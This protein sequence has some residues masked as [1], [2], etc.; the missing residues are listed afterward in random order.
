MDA[1]PSDQPVRSTKPPDYD[2]S[3][4][5]HQ[6]RETLKD[7]TRI[8]D[9]RQRPD[10]T[11]GK[12]ADAINP[13]AQMASN[14]GGLDFLL[15]GVNSLSE[16]LP[17]LVKVLDEISKIHPYIGIVVGAFKVVIELEVKRRD[18]DKKVNL[19]FLE[20]KNMMSALLQLQN[21]RPN[22][23]GR[24]GITV[25]ARLEDLV[26]DAAVDIKECANACDTYMR[27]RLLVKV[28]KGAIWDETLK[29][30]VQTFADRKTAFVF[31]LSIHTGMSIDQAND[32]LDELMNRMDILLEFFQ[33]TSSYEQR[34]LRNIIQKAGGVEQVLQQTATMQ[35][36][37]DRERPLEDTV[38]SYR[39][40]GAR[41]LGHFERLRRSARTSHYLSARPSQYHPT[42]GNAYRESYYPTVPHFARPRT[43]F[44]GPSDDEDPRTAALAAELRELKQELADTP[45]A[46][47]RKNLKIF[48]RRFQMQQREILEE[49]RKVVIHEGDRVIS[50]VLAGPHERIIDPTL[51]EIWKDMRWR[52]IVKARHLVLALH[53][54]YMQ[55]MEDQ[56]R[57][58]KLDPSAPRRISEADTWTLKYLGL[59]ELQRI[60]EALD[61]DASGYITIQEVNRFAT[62]RPQG[63]S[64]LHWL[65]YWAVGW[66]L[67]MTEYKRKIQNLLGGI[68]RSL[69][70]VRAPNRAFVSR[71]L[72]VVKRLVDRMT[73]QFQ[74]N[75]ENIALLPR[76]QAYIHQ[77]E[78]QLRE[79]LEIAKYDIDALDTLA[80]VNGRKGLEKNLY[81]VVYLMLLHHLE[82]IRAG[83][84]VILHLE[85]LIDAETAMTIIEDGY[86]LR[87]SLLSALFQQRRLL[88]HQEIEDF[89]CGMFSGSTVII[90]P[91]DEPSRSLIGN[92]DE[93]DLTAT[94]P[95]FTTLKYPPHLDEFYPV[96][97]DGRA[98]QTDSDNIDDSLQPLLGPW[99]G[100]IGV[101]Y[102]GVPV[103]SILN[104]VFHIA[105]AS[106]D[107]VVASPLLFQPWTST[108]V[109]LV[110]EK[111]ESDDGR[112]Y[113]VTIRGNSSFFSSMYLRLRLSDDGT[114][115]A[116]YCYPTY[117]FELPRSPD[118]A[119][120]KPIPVVLK[121]NSSP[122]VMAFY[123]STAE[124]EAGRSRALWRFAISAV[125]YRIR[126]RN[127]SWD[128]IKSRRD[129][130]RRLVSL[131]YYEAIRDSISGPSLAEESRR[132]L[133]RALPGD[134]HFAGYA[135]TDPERFPW[136][137]PPCLDP[138]PNCQHPGLLETTV[139]CVRCLSCSPASSYPGYGCVF[140]GV[141]ECLYDHLLYRSPLDSSG[142]HCIVK[143]R[144]LGWTM[145]AFQEAT[146]KST[147]ELLDRVG[148]IRKMISGSS[149]GA[150]MKPGT[151]VER[152][153]DPRPSPLMQAKDRLKHNGGQ[154]DKD[155]D[156]P[157]EVRE[158]A[159]MDAGRSE[160]ATDRNSRPVLCITC[161]EK[162]TL[163][164]WTCAECE[165]SVTICDA[166][167]KNGG[168]DQGTHKSTHTLLLAYP[169]EDT[170]SRS[171]SPYSRSRRRR[172]PL[173]VAFA[174]TA[175]QTD[176]SGGVNEQRL[177]AVEERLTKIEDRFE[178]VESGVARMERMLAAAL[179]ALNVPPAT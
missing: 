65:A 118:G 96:N 144:V 176:G 160:T 29:G 130:N 54:Y 142:Q 26:K 27:K 103:L 56:E 10:S 68:Q 174:P 18:N 113:R 88:V 50:S 110:A 38:Q 49:M 164:C 4:E 25:G 141:T 43:G 125:L 21:V 100:L 35:E 80:L 12:V 105:P 163:P 170:R 74:G 93:I 22:H 16:S 159:T 75:A 31:A 132:L 24:D 131:L 171:V 7:A 69:E 138:S 177:E 147:V 168:I 116:G 48:E 101:L 129:R 73:L 161:T 166:C 102:Q 72:S 78:A 173:P 77:E 34:T 154:G 145:N 20:M 157:Q 47:M 90:V 120:E 153:R 122:E 98:D 3:S 13:T 14:S 39:G 162:V 106:T 117:D 71:Y 126:Q 52:G 58:L 62:S 63:W 33:K 151:T 139:P 107:Q 57:D 67:S 128:F 158:L 92:P 1:L 41:S 167:D 79:A 97:D 87:S 112:T 42:P 127:F 53:D 143:T 85:E 82:I 172:S 111:L 46:A 84:V 59:T 108:H 89:A 44:E 178:A 156:E 136:I 45:A 5:V 83:H 146:K 165:E 135:A 55:K 175:V 70:T 140:C 104:A 11:F 15:D 150:D 17:A 32:K 37:L 86:V 8:H 40:M 30:Y 6:A 36:L 123:P 66:Q 23:V 76:F 114:T 119:E 64:L 51:Y 134:L 137:L 115:L 99:T 155:G 28:I 121:H 124:R 60:I 152:G 148:T 81:V 95:P 2:V 169:G 91:S 149:E 9:E 61:D 19:L 133:E 109:D 179:A 94:Q